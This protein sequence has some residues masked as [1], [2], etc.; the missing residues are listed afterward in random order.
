[1]HLF[2]SHTSTDWPPLCDQFTTFT[3]T[4][5]NHKLRRHGSLP[6][7]TFRQERRAS[8]SVTHH[9]DSN[10]SIALHKPS[11]Q[12]L[13]NESKSTPATQQRPEVQI[14]RCT[15]SGEESSRITSSST[16]S[17]HL[18]ID[19]C[20]YFLTPWRLRTSWQACL[21]GLRH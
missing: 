19:S 17:D 14:F 10:L 16:S 15:P 5:S 2:Q 9:L 11:T 6:R 1:M 12:F 21:Q 13:N 4:D 7:P 3:F 8:S 20:K 18:S